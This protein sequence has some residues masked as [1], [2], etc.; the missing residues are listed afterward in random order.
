MG[1]K[2]GM[3]VSVALGEVIAL[4][5][6]DVIAAYPITP[7]THI[8]EHLADLVANGKLDAEFV[9]VE[10]EHSAMSACLGSAAA[11]GRTFTATAGQGLELMHEVLY[12]ASAMRLPIVMSVAN[13]ALSSPLSVWGDHSDAMAVR[14]TGWIQIFTENGQEVMDNI[15]CAFHIAE[16]HRVLLPI[17]VHLDGFNLSHVIEPL[18]LPEQGEVDGFLPPINYPLPLDPRKPVAMGDF[19][20]PVIYTEAKWAQEVNLRKSKDV[21]KE[22]WQ[23]FGEQFGRYYSPVETYHGDAR[24]LLFTMGSFSETAMTAIDKMRDEGRD[25]GLVRLRLWRPFPFKEFREAV[26]GAEVLVTLDRSLSFGGPGGAVASEIK[27]ALY[28]E[29]DKPRVVS[30]VGGLGGRDIHVSDFEAIINRGIEIAERGS[31]NEFEIFGVRE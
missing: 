23:K 25:V 2:V 13:R 8:V 19:G 5:D 6:T 16:D 28:D 1:T 22:V 14:D 27:A 29:K 18:I 10:S 11:G 15:L 12:V 7:Q 24:V 31:E 17:M 9:P 20:P 21:I 30:F 4:T 26:K 3:E